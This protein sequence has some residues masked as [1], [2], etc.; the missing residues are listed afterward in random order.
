MAPRDLEPLPYQNDL[1]SWLKREDAALWDWHSA[2][3]HDPGEIGSLRLQLLKTTYRLDHGTHA[4]LYARAAALAARLGLTVPITCYQAQPQV[5]LNASL[6]YIPGEVHIVFMGPLLTVLGD[7]EVDAV[8]GH[9]LGHYMLWSGYDG[10]FGIAERVLSAI[11][12][13]GHAEPAHLQTCRRW[14]LAAELFA[15]QAALAACADLDTVVATLVR[16]ETGAATVDAPA[17]LRQAAEV[18]QTDGV[19]AEGPTHPEC[20]IR[21]AALAS[22]AQGEADAQERIARWLN[23]PLDPRELDVLGQRTC[24]ELTRSLLQHLLEPTWLR[25]EAVLAHAH[26]FFPAL[27]LD[28]LDPTCAERLH[29]QLDGCSPGLRD[30]VGS[31]LIDCAAA[32]P[33]LM[34]VAL[35]RGFLVAE[36]WGIGDR[37][38]ELAHRDLKL[39]VKEV[40]K[41]RQQAQQLVTAAAAA[42]A[43]SPSRG[44]P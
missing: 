34:E 38:A 29:G 18:L 3:R 16:I 36:P 28:G 14:R 39:K 32:D 5:L 41:L 44:G 1:V 17:Y 27:E 42:A 19:Q 37:L 10:R 2:V 24:L 23:G 35:A 13:D 12:A 43:A 31:L 6:Q 21:A 22:H 9:E 26:C 8:I 20:F 7:G 30:Y 25:S 40:A 4:G 33:D 15:D 11:A